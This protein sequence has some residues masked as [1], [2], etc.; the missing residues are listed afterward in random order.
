VPH[1]TILNKLDNEQ[2][3]IEREPATRLYEIYQRAFDVLC[4]AYEVLGNLPDGPERDE[5]VHAHGEATD[6]VLFGLRAKL[7]ALYPDLEAQPEAEPTAV[8]L[9]PLAEVVD[10]PLTIDADVLQALSN[11]R[12]R[13]KVIDLPGVDPKAERE[14]LSDVLSQLADT[15]LRGIQAHPRKLWVMEQFQRSLVVVEKEDSEGKEHFGTELESVMD[16]LGIDSSDG[17]LTFY[18]GGI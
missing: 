17:L 4:G 16:I 8:P 5:A 18:L 10:E 12:S 11:F 3:M 14:R 13:A 15:L 7:I 9:D 1:D 6:A 2:A